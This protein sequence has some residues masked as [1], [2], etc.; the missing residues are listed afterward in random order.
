MITETACTIPQKNLKR[1]HVDQKRIRA[2]IDP[3]VNLPPITVQTNK[4]PHKAN[5][6]EILDKDGEVIARFVYRPDAPLSCGARLWVE[7]NA[8]IRTIV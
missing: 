6:V 5:E 7:T 8:E 3:D 4:G 1:I 2:N